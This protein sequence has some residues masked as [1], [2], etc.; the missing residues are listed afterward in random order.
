M[1][2]DA[3]DTRLRVSLASY[4][5]ILCAAAGRKIS[6]AHTLTFIDAHKSTSHLCALCVLCA[7]KI[8]IHVRCALCARQISIAHTLTFID[9]HKSTSHLRALCVLCARKIMIHVRCALCVRQMIILV[10]HDEI[11]SV[12]PNHDVLSWVKR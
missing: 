6:I 5:G 7:R 3:R 10:R 9:A 8:M 2:R 11:C 12:C 4:H 1:Q